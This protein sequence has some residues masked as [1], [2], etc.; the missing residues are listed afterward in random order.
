M[1]SKMK[2]GT[3]HD[4]CTRT[5]FNA[6]TGRSK[7]VSKRLHLPNQKIWIMI[8]RPWPRLKYAER[9][10]S[11]AAEDAT[12]LIL[13]EGIYFSCCGTVF[14]CFIWEDPPPL[15]P[16]Q[17]PPLPWLCWEEDPPPQHPPPLLWLCWEEEDPP[18]QHPPPLLWLCWEEDDPLLQH[19]QRPQQQQQQQ[20][21]PLCCCCWLIFVVTLEDKR[22]R[23]FILRVDS[24]LE[25]VLWCCFEACKGF[26]PHNC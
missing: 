25:N 12:Y 18:P 16:P 14:C 23:G 21:P 11:A 2:R 19:A 22:K 8:R 4:I 15:L 24:N 3:Q 7:Q 20:P 17:H 6:F 9:E 13:L 5:I 26:L 1:C 10:G